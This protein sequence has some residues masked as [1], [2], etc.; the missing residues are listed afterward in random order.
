MGGYA[1]GVWSRRA[2]VVALLVLGCQDVR[3]ETPS[4]TCSRYCDRTCEEG[5]F[6][7]SEDSCLRECTQAMRDP[8]KK[9]EYVCAVKAK[10]CRT[11]WRCLR[12]ASK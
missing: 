4:V 9:K 11:V 3:G 2:L 5:P 10:D 7:T 8:A 1:S 12:S 6:T